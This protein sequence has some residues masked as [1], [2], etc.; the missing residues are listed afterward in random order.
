M[1]SMKRT[2]LLTTMMVLIA[3][4]ACATTGETTAAPPLADPGG[5]IPVSGIQ[6]VTQTT[7]TGQPATGTA[8][9]DP[10]V[11]GRALQESED[12]MT[13]AGTPVTE[14]PTAGMEEPTLSPPATAGPEIQGDLILTPLGGHGP[15]EIFQ[16]LSGEEQDCIRANFTPEER[17]Q[18]LELAGTETRNVENA[19]RMMRCAGEKTLLRVLITSIVKGPEP[20]TEQTSD[21]IWNGFSKIDKD[22]MIRNLEADPHSGEPQ[23]AGQIKDTLAGSM[24]TLHCL[25]D[26]EWQRTEPDES[27]E[28]ERRMIA[29]AVNEIGGPENIR[30]NMDAPPGT[31][32]KMFDLMMSCPSP[33]RGGG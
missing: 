32:S 12:E 2:T 21:C 29:C 22:G 14:A 3:L 16:S 20:F 26:E 19:S 31:M 30:E 11:T 13:D 23:E 8:T 28:A 5:Q 6:E 17:E 27:M 7:V 25:N 1:K 15:Q 18:M 10:P 9:S 4:T 24:I 33:T